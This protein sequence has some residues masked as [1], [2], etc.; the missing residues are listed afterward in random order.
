[1]HQDNLFPA[2]SG[3]LAENGEGKG[4][5]YNLNIPLPPGCG[6]G[7]YIAALERVVLPALY[8]FKPELIVVPSG[9]D[10]SGVD[11]LGRMMVTTGGYR[12]MTKLL[13]KAA[14]DLCGGRLVMSHEGGYSA[15]YVP[16]CGLAVLEEMSGIQT[17]V[18]DP[19]GSHILN[20]GQQSL[21]PHQA[22]AIDA[23]AKLVANIS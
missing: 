22:Q 10:A 17:G 5:G 3:G 7:A 8:K 11:P 6:D 9:F 12:S 18:E 1:L 13:L 23:A 15:T 20:W 2:D 21:Q 14:D 19:W 4:R 16:Y